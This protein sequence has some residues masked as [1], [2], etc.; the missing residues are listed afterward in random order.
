MRL[1]GKTQ[2]EIS[3]KLKLAVPQYWGTKNPNV[4]GLSCFLHSLTAAAV[5]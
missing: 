1:T 3:D 5:Y 4:T 2:E